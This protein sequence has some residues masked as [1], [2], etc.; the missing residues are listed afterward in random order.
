M[1]LAPAPNAPKGGVK[2]GDLKERNCRWPHGDPREADFHF[3][4]AQINPGMPYCPH[5][6]RVA[7]HTSRSG[8]VTEAP[9]REEIT[10][11]DMVSSVVNG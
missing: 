1:A 10:L 7:Y 4:G 2:M 6:C 8:R 11:E 5:H 3:C 9:E